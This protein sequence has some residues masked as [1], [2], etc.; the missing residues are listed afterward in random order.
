MI[1]LELGLRF[2]LNFIAEEASS[3]S[4]F[5]EIRLGVLILRMLGNLCRSVE[6]SSFYCN[7]GKMLEFYFK[8]PFLAIGCF[9]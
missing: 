4:E 3:H 1:S 8:E 7:L 9:G 5:I 2:A 6:F